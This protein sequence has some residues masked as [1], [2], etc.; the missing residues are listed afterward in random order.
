[1]ARF[2]PLPE[3]AWRAALSAVVKTLP[4]LRMW[5]LKQPFFTSTLLP[6]V[7]RPVR[8]TLRRLYF[9]PVQLAER[10]LGAAEGL[11]PPKSMIFTGSVEGFAPSGSRL[12]DRLVEFGGLTPDSHVLDIGCGLG[13][14]AVPLMDYLNAEGAYVGMDIVPS[15]IEWCNARIASS[16]ANFTFT[17]ADIANR[18]YNPTGKY[19]AATYTFPYD[20]ESFDLVVLVS[21]F[22]HMLTAEMEHYVD[23]ITRV[24]K[25]G[26]RCF[27][28]YFLVNDEST[29]LM[30]SGKSSVRFKH[31]VEPYW[32]VNRRV[33]EL[34]VGY[35]EPYIRSV[36]ARPAAFAEHV[37]HYGGWCGRRPFWSAESGLGDQDVV[38]A[39]KRRCTPSDERALD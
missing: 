17:L 6:A 3:R 18:E 1:V 35:D 10:R 2:N 39:T 16:Y 11:A 33:P 14:L 24:L 27:A 20:D 37:I 7:P 26:G 15:G 9:L 13:R 25:P 34:G 30:E 31:R 5:L 29:A 38:V 19:Q 12:V 8:W 22:T 32:L 36:Y 21:V 4:R 23:E 28:T